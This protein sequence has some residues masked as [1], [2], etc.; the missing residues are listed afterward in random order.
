MPKKL[1][2]LYFFVGLLCN[3]FA[4]EPAQKWSWNYYFVHNMFDSNCSV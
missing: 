4:L 2:A 1:L 3:I